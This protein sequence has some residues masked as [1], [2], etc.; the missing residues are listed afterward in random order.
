MANKYLYSFQKD[1]ELRLGLIFSIAGVVA[2]VM[3]LRLAVWQG[4]QVMEIH[5][6]RDLIAQIP[7]MKA[8]IQSMGA[9]NGLV[10]SGI[11]AGKDH[12]MAV[13]NNV[14]L[15]VGGEIDGR[16]VTAITE[17]GV[18]ACEVGNPTKCIHLTVAE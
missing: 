4:L 5:R 16:K 9:V 6:K 18:T 2:C 12:P 11:V 7:A 3:V 15:N 14:L 8:K 1:R 10:L 13:I 17:E